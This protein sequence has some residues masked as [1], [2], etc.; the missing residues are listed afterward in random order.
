LS[1]NWIQLAEEA[2]R[3]AYARSRLLGHVRAV[4]GYCE[5]LASRLPQADREAVLVAAWFHDLARVDEGPEDHARRSAERAREFLTDRGYPSDRSHQV[6]LAVLHH[7]FPLH[8]PERDLLPVEAKILYDA[9]K[10]DR[11]KGYYLADLL[12]DA[13]CR[14]LREGTHWA[15]YLPTVRESFVAG[16]ESLYTAPARELVGPDYRA[17]LDFLDR[18]ARLLS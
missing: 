2:T 8:G 11:M 14:A 17:S 5:E 4:V 10:L 15:V 13:G 12:A 6:A 3:E 9:D 7:S 18:V 16:Y 1:V